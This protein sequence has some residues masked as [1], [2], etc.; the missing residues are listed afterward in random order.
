M[1]RDFDYRPSDGNGRG[2]YPADWPGWCEAI[3]A[4]ERP[5]VL[6]PRLQR[7]T[8]ARAL[9]DSDD[10]LGWGVLLL[11]APALFAGLLMLGQV[12]LHLF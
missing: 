6:R 3:A 11:T 2:T 1:P 12:T 5:I 9:P 4:E 7:R 10:L 8:A